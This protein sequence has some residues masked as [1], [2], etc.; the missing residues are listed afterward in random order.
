MQTQTTEDR[1]AWTATLKKFEGAVDW[2]ARI[3][4]VDTILPYLALFFAMLILARAK[5]SPWIVLALSLPAGGFLTRSFIIFHDCCHGSYL[6]SRKLNDLLG[7]ALG[8]LVF[9]PFADWRRS[10]GI[11]HVTAGNLDRRGLGDVWTMTVGEY[12]ASTRFERLRY[13]LYRN[14]LVLFVLG[15]FF[16]FV[17]TNRFPS[18]GAKGAQLRDLILHDTALVAI[19]AGLSLAF[20]LLPYL[21]VQGSIL[22]AGGM[23]GI[24]MFYVQH[25]FDPSYWRHGEGWSFFDA[26]MEGS[27]WYRLPP[28]LQWITGNIGLHHVHHLAPRIPNYRLQACLDAIPEL[29][30]KNNLGIVRSLRSISLNLWDEAAGGLISF[31]ALRR[32]G[33]GAALS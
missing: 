14:P 17:V 16:I 1:P 27:S 11:H 6:A 10:H 7:R 30:L 8:L 13:R 21:F 3:Q 33:V 22:L 28:A 5:V 32:R 26:A 20:G 18:R 12:E 15:P 4:L 24:W 19:A 2:R 29:R 31:G 25:Q 23:V 9:T